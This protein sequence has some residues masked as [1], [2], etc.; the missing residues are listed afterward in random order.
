MLLRSCT[1]I[2]TWEHIT[3]RKCTDVT[4]KEFVRNAVIYLA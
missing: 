4:L 3:G 2:V 1:L